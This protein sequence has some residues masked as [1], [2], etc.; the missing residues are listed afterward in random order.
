MGTSPGLATLL[1]TEAIS[2]D[3]KKMLYA[4]FL[5]A[6][7]AFDVVWHDSML[8]KLYHWT[9]G[10]RLANSLEGVVPKHELAGQMG[11][12][13]IN[14]VHGITGTGLHGYNGINPK[15][16]LQ[17]WNIYIKPRVIYGLENIKLSNGDRK[18]LNQYHKRWLKQMLQ[19]PE[20]TADEGVYIIAGEIPIE[21]E[22][23]RKILT[24]LM[25]IFRGED[26]EKDIA[27]RQL[28]V[29]D[30]TSNSWFIYAGK[31]LEKYDL[32]KIHDLLRTPIAKGV[33][34]KQL[35]ESIINFWKRD[36]L[37]KAKEI[38]PVFV[39]HE[40]PRWHLC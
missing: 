1:L 12:E 18:R 30:S 14:K 32:S 24:Q 8:H 21:A 13:L 39:K 38:K 23:D 11:R 20:R 17:I 7:K 35:T 26:I 28:A 27:E 37:E 16:G 33:W 34:K 5:D 3:L 10:D 36:I 19:L 2:E 9:K 4:T 15:I 40:C 6:S 31:I 29:K 25:Q 22:I